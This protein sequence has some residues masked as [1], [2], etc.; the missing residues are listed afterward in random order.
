[1]KLFFISI[2]YSLLTILGFLDN[3]IWVNVK[4]PTNNYAGEKFTVEITVNKLD[5]KHFAEF[6]QKLPK[7]F[8]AVEKKSGSAE[9]SF[10]NQELKFVWLR[11]P[12]E[13]KFT[14]SFDIIT[15]KNV[16]GT[17]NIQGYF[18]YIYNNQRGIAYSNSQIINIYLKGEGYNFNKELRGSL[19]YPPTDTKL[20]QCLR[21]KPFYSTNNKDL[22]VKL[23]VSKGE[24]KGTAKIEEKIPQDY[25]AKVIS[26]KGA[27]FGH[28]NNKVI[29]LWS[30]LPKQKNFEIIYKL[31]P[32]TSNLNI[33]TINGYFN[34]LRGNQLVKKEIVEIN[35]KKAKNKDKNIG[36]NDIKDYFLKQK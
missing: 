14:I 8:K 22:I 33:P 1:M 26:A 31:I 12:R 7:G 9:F 23:L 35:N 36:T 34:Y 11:L 2:V 18:T 25:I 15:E 19:N 6:R 24:A 5:L 30:E 20:V 32:S 13:P 4:T 28:K 17:F 27:S 10:S 3:Q 29:F 21:V 16:S